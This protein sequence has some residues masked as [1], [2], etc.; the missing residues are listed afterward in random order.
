MTIAVCAIAAVAGSS[1]SEASAAVRTQRD[2]QIQLKTR[3]DSDH[4]GTLTAREIRRLLI[5]IIRG[6]IVRDAVEDIDGD[7]TVNRADTSA[8]V[9]AF[10]ALL[11]ARC[12]NSVIDIDEECDD[13]NTINTD[14][15]SNACRVPVCGDGIVQ[16]PEECDDGVSGFDYCRDN[17]TLAQCTLTAFSL[18][19]GSGPTCITPRFGGMYVGCSDG[20]EFYHWVPFNGCMSNSELY[21]L[22]VSLCKEHRCYEIPR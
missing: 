3:G 6:V 5:T 4:D 16:S 19:G 11:A 1:V 15:C 12:G 20:A 9:T 14:Q 8:A 18:L 7:G 2:I 22:A 21:D 10:R 17:C 13:G